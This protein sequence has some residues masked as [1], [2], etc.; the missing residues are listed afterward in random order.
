M[1]LKI[2]SFGSTPTKWYPLLR[3]AWTEALENKFKKQIINICF[4][5]I[6]NNG[7]ISIETSK[8]TYRLLM[9][10]INIAN[11]PVEAV[12]SMTT[13]LGLHKASINI[14]IRIGCF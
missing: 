7:R 3:H 11:T 8:Q 1:L 9:V 13:T 2:R 12:T 10:G 6:A 14:C 4:I 5:S